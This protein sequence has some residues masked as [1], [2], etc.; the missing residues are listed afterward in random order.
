M[1]RNIPSAML[2][3][4]TAP[5]W[6]PAIFVQM[7]FSSTTVY[8]WSG[9]GTISWNGNTWTGLGSLLSIGNVMEDGATVEARGIVITLS[10]LNSTLLP[11][12]I[13]EVQLGLPVTVWLG[14]LS[15]AKT[16]IA[17]PLILWSGGIDQPTISVS[18]ETAT[19]AIA[20]ENLL[21]SMNVP[22]DRRY[23]AID[24]QSQWPKD[25][26][27]LFVPSLL[28]TNLLWG[29]FSINTPNI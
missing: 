15:A 3:A 1:P 18:G 16:V 6:N 22:V 19:M 25:L 27:L 11:N 17:S 12:V 9:I 24:L 29:E 28:E 20:C 21:V 7:A 26:G 4:I 13:G 23:N 5:Q 2:A 8:V 10:G 14:A